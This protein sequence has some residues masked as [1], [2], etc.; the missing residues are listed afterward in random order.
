MT[1][2][3]PWWWLALAGCTL[4]WL[5]VASARVAFRLLGPVTIEALVDRIGEERTEF[6]RKSLRAPTA[7]WFSLSLASGATMLAALVVL[8]AGAPRIGDGPGWGV[9]LYPTGS[10]SQ[11][12]ALYGL[13]L[14][15]LCA[16]E[17]LLPVVLARQ[18]RASFIEASLPILRL[19]HVV[20][21]PLTSLL[22]RW[23]SAD[24]AERDGAEEEPAGEEEV[25]AFIDVGT[26]EGIVE[27]GEGELLRNVLLFG[28]TRV[29]E[30][31]TPRTAI[32]AIGRTATVGDL[33]QIIA[34]TRF[35]RI[36]IHDG[37]IDGVVGIAALK[38][39]VA[40]MQAGRAGEAAT[41]LMTAPYFVPESKN[42]AELLREMQARRKPL[43]IVADEY[44]GTA[45]LVTIED[46]LEELVGEIREE[47]EEGEDVVRAP[48]GTW[49]VR[50]R[51]SLHDVG[52]VLDADLDRDAAG[53][54]TV[55]GMLMAALDRVPAPGEV[56]ERAGH[57]FVVEEADR[58]RVLLV[59]IAR[60]SPDA[61]ADGRA[62]EAQA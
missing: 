35:S 28:E 22:A 31:M 44:G 32:V 15:V 51:A 42:V 20:A 3:S 37:T 30:V 25:Q 45:G 17:F 2:H 16:V 18:D 4:A 21:L 43:A 33:V 47:H 58:R 23:S 39:A 9:A 40:A 49:L 48:D 41:S 60:V 12:L 5:F 29:A 59:R 19:V 54:S 27:E 57:R 10:P 11:G 56:I 13:L 7:F 34:A 55:G 61:D 6:L 62:A 36:P 26:R 1:T 52:E 46:L 24:E 38:D 53:Q 50:G 14:L 8:F